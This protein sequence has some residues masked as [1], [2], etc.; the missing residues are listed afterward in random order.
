MLGL[1]GTAVDSKVTALRNIKNLI[2]PTPLLLD[3]RS[4]NE[5]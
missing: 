4:S 1:L 3:N 5:N 2:K